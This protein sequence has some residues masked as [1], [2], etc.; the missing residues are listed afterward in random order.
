MY[1]KSWNNKNKSEKC[2][3]KVYITWFTTFT[4]WNVWNSEIAHD[5]LLFCCI[6]KSLGQIGG[7]RRAI[8][9]AKQEKIYYLSLNEIKTFLKKYK[10]Y[11]GIKKIYIWLHVNIVICDYLFP[12]FLYKIYNKLI[13]LNKPKN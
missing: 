1:S 5:Y 9:W 8:K 12:K 4:N 7:F 11:K 3:L 10:P 2:G 13:T 6:Y